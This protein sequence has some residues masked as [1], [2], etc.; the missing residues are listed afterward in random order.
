[1]AQTFAV[2]I[3]TTSSIAQSISDASTALDSLRS[4]FSG[5]TAPTDPTPVAGQ[6]WWDTA[7]GRLMVF[8]GT[9]WL[10]TGGRLLENLT[11][12]SVAGTSEEDLQSVTLAA[13]TL[14]VNGQRL[15]IVAVGTCAANNNA[16]TIRLYFGATVIGSTPG[17]TAGGTADD[18][19]IVA[20][21]IRTGASAQVC[22]AMCGF[23]PTSG[24][25]GDGYVRTVGAISLASNVTIKTTGDGGA[26]SDIT[27]TALWVELIH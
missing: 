4:G 21:V 18:W 14:S 10:P 1:M 23:N 26:A 13:N 5:A 25:N 3:V 15:R 22:L 16:K 17:S 9:L 19:G 24:G 12:A 7:T 2:P 20:D 11:P 6:T 27:S 8:N